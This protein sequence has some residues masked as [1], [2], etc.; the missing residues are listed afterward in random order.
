M[1]RPRFADTSSTHRAVV[2]GFLKKKGQ[3]LIAAIA[4]YGKAFPA[5]ARFEVCKVSTL[6]PKPQNPES[7]NT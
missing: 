5:F 4:R 6:S 1:Q 3:W 7:P 2:K